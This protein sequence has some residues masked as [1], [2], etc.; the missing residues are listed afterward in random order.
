[1]KSFKKWFFALMSAF[2][3]LGAAT[4]CSDTSSKTDDSN[5]EQTDDSTQND[6]SQTE[7]NSKSGQ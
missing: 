1:M 5:A 2:M 7:E 6:G 4:A 3:L